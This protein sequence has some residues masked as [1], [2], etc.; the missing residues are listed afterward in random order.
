[1]DRQDCVGR[2]PRFA[3]HIFAMMVEPSAGRSERVPGTTR[4]RYLHFVGHFFLPSPAEQSGAGEHLCWVSSILGCRRLPLPILGN[5]RV[6]ENDKFS[7]DGDEADLW[8]FAFGGEMLTKELHVPVVPGGG[9]SGEVEHAPNDAPS[10]PDDP[11]AFAFTRIVCN[12]N[13]A[14]GADLLVGQGSKL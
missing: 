2:S 10:S 1:M 7:G 3:S 13:N 8:R 12:G 6:G 11:D 9:K 14:Q 5:E 4:D